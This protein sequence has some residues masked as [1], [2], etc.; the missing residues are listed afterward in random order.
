[1]RLVLCTLG[2]IVAVFANAE[3]LTLPDEAVSIEEMDEA[4]GRQNVHIDLDVI[5]AESDIH[6]Y[7]S[8]NVANNTVSGNNVLSPGAFADSSGLSNVIQNTGNNVLIQS[9]TVVNLTL[10]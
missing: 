1:M 6:G 5:Y 9:S 2:I 10:K 3:E 7:S 4:R 8:G